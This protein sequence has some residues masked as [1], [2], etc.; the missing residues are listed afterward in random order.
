MGRSL[1]LYAVQMSDHEKDKKICMNWE[2]QREYDEILYELEDYLT[3]KDVNCTSRECLY[4]KN[5][6]YKYNVLDMYINQDWCPKCALFTEGLT[7]NNPLVKKSIDFS[8]SYSNSIWKSKW[9]FYNMYPGD[10]NA[11]FCNRFIGEKYRQMYIDKNTY[12]S[13]NPSY[14]KHML[15]TYGKPYCT[16]DREAYAET[17]EFI[18]FC[19][20]WLSKPDIIVIYETE[21]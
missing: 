20:E 15:E 12:S 8:H 6:P 2:Y 5:Y 4:D 14:I 18:S 13:N 19:E 21:L 11:D 9:H 10:T 16:V 3:N 7:S 1:A 17:S